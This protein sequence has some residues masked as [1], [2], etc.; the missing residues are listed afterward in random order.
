MSEDRV[1]F[2]ETKYGLFKNG[3]RVRFNVEN[4]DLWAGL[5]E[6]FL[7]HID[8]EVN[9]DDEWVIDSDAGIIRTSTGIR[10]GFYMGS[11]RKSS[12]TKVRCGRIE[13]E[14]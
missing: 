1:Y 6:G 10:W 12:R 11:V 4:Q 13:N 2:L 5:L 9:P 7:Q 14:R 8:N 3:D